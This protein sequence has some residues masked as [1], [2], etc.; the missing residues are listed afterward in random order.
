MSCREK[1]RAELLEELEELHKRIALLEQASS[2]NQNEQELLRFQLA[3]SSASDAIGMTTPDGIHFYQNRS[4]CDL[5]GFEKAEDL[6]AVGGGPALYEDQEVAAEVFRAI[7]SGLS[8]EG[9]V[10]MKTSTGN[11]LVVFL[12]ANALK[13]DSGKIVGVIG[14]HTDITRQKAAEEELQKLAAVIKHTKELVNMSTLD[15]Q[16]VFLNEAG[17]QMLGIDPQAVEQVNIIEVIPDHLVGFVER[18]LLPTLM[19]G[20]VWEGDLQ[21]KNLQTGG[22]TDV[23]AMTFTVKSSDTGQPWFLANVSID[24]TERKQAEEELRQLRN[25]LTNIIDSMPSVLVGVDADGNVT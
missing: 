13:D 10:A 3:V 16:M 20:E 12:R 6:A 7:M 24:I 22:I 15:G 25:Y 14:V 21:Y 23:H 4:F 5:F 11:R 8:W 1:S 2:R 19:R 9:E 18:E 17:G